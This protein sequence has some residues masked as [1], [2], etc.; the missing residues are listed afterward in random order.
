MPPE[1]SSITATFFLNLINRLG[2][3]P[4]PASAFLLSNVVQPVTLVDTD[5]A[6]PT[7]FQTPVLDQAFTAGE[8]VAPGAGV[9]LAD[10]GALPAGNYNVR[11]L[12]SENGGSASSSDIKLQRRDAANA[13]NIW[14]QLFLINPS[15]SSLIDISMTVKL[16]V[17]ERI[18]VVQ[19]AA[20]PA[21][22][23]FQANLWA[24]LTTV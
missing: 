2:V 16:A 11:M 24:S 10:T 14:S 1:V 15:D 7:T 21:G 12:Y 9:V 19:G 4:P 23:T 8:L 3:R 17:N 20:A 18:R 13:A 22:A 6:I 5:I